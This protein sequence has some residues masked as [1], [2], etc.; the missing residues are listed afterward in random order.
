MCGS[1][2]GNHYQKTHIQFDLRTGCW[3]YFTQSCDGDPET[4]VIVFSSSVVA[5]VLLR[6]SGFIGWSSIADWPGLCSYPPLYPKGKRNNEELNVFFFAPVA[7]LNPLKV[8]FCS[9]ASSSSSSFP[10][11]HFSRPVRDASAA[12]GSPAC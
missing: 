6:R 7:E 9:A 5:A 2:T 1:Q 11:V 3:H 12:V 10:R 4:C 8:S